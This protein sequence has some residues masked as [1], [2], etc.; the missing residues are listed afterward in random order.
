MINV[1]FH[2]SLVPFLCYFRG[3]LVSVRFCVLSF[4][5]RSHRHLLFLTCNLNN[6]YFLCCPLLVSAVRRCQLS[7]DLASESAS[8]CRRSARSDREELLKR[9]YSPRVL[10]QRLCLI[11]R[12]VHRCM[13]A[14]LVRIR[15]KMK[16]S[17]KHVAIAKAFCESR[18]SS[19]FKPVLIL[20]CSKMMENHSAWLTEGKSS[21]WIKCDGKF[22]A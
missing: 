7:L 16:T 11:Q 20:L 4:F 22:L 21:E 6:L 12:S 2:A 13:T 9:I 14:G 5:F 8:L 17:K 3:F 18:D 15:E 1:T 19:C 10:L